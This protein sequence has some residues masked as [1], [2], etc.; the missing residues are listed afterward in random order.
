MKIRSKAFVILFTFF[1]TQVFVISNL[2]IVHASTSTISNDYL[3]F[4]VADNG[5]FTVG[6]T[7]GDLGNPNDNN[8]IMLY[9]H[10]I[11]GTSYTTIKVDGND[12]IYSPATTNTDFATLSNT[13]T[14]TVGNVVINQKISIVKN[15]S[16][17][18]EDTVEIKYTAT[19]NDSVQ[20]EV[21]TR[22]MMDTMLGSNDAAPFR[23]PGI[24]A[25]T[26]EKELTGSDI[27]E[28]WQAFD[29]LLNPT[30][31]AQGT[32]LKGDNKPDKVQF[33]NWRRIYN[34]NW[35]YTVDPTQSNG[36]SA[37]SV[38]WNPKSLAAGETREY[39]TY[40]GIS[41]FQ[42]DLRP[43]LALSVT[44]ANNLEVI[45]G[46][47]N[48]NPFAVTAYITNIGSS[49]GTD[50]KATINLPAGLSLANGQSATVALG[51][52]QPNQD[53]QVS[54]NVQADPA[55][56][57]RHLTY[58]IVLES[59]NSDT[60]T[61]NRDIYIP[62]IDSGIDSLSINPNA[63]TLAPGQSKQ[64][65]VTGTKSSGNVVDLTQSTSGTTY[66]SSNTNLVTV[67]ENGLISIPVGAANGVAYVRAYNNG[68]VTAATVTISSQ[69]TSPSG[70]T[71]NPTTV[72]LGQGETQQLT[73]T[74][75]MPDGSIKDVT[76][77][78]T[79]TTYT[80][81]NTA[82]ATVD[83]NGLITVLPAATVGYK[84]LITAQ[85]GGKVVSCTV[86]VGSASVTVNSISLDTT[87]A[88][89]AQGATKQ[90][91]VTGT[92]SD[93]ST[94]D[95]TNSST[96]TTY[97]SSNTS[98][99]TV[100]TNGLITVLP[101]ATVGYKTVILANNNG[102]TASCTVTVGSSV[103]TVNSISL[104]TT[105][106]TLAQ[107]ATKQLVVTGTMSDGS[108]KD[109]TSSS[110]GTTYTSSNLAVATVDANGLITVLPTAI[111]GYKTVILANNNGKTASCTVTV[112]SAAVTVNSISLDTTAATL[113]QGATKQLVVT[114]TM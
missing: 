14:Y 54:W 21:G 22:I 15:S 17:Q 40:Y 26:T 97:T 24:G 1:F 55:T 84:T 103:V 34:T 51:T 73:V 23:I 61:I 46:S 65:T 96:G 10:P 44:G 43:P 53:S 95:L 57:D 92:M 30:V 2:N 9:G 98:V 112:G 6:T 27:P 3:E 69:G 108:T 83:A 76:N 74:G 113:A 63:V 28:Y 19:N 107:I 37:V 106:A 105:A 32:L 29:D 7:G 18:K 70:L 45:N 86:T 67:N 80:S 110:T 4:A 20:H 101:T 31:I 114:G 56:V 5:R 79:G 64:L 13:S 8:K 93:G 58:S 66:S 11:P 87:A 104:D 52:L 91:L 72:T 62:S 49:A 33:T 60:K 50:V 100:D 81:S 85:N 78:S 99:A 71:I 90:L 102:K 39:T 59:S 38:Y 42:Q 41:Q 111:V 12:Y 35:D 94:K 47:Y 75:T 68:K 36:D 109:L 89:L 16:T 82:V 25:V 88:T 48:P 77:S